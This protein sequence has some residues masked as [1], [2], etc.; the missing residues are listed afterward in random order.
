VYANGGHNPPYLLGA[1]G[2]ILSLPRTKGKLLAMF[3]NRAYSTAE[4]TLSPGDCLYLYTDGVTE[5]EDNS[6]EQFGVE[7]LEQAL[8][9]SAG[10][11]EQV[12]GDVLEYVTRFVDN[13]A[14]ADDITC[15]SLLR[16]GHSL[17]ATTEGD[18]R[19]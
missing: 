14:Q 1:D 15:L 6:G 12:I 18:A 8:T 16:R 5:A 4:I 7:R 9:H 13:A 3:P 10:K 2:R 17:A 19:S 11:A